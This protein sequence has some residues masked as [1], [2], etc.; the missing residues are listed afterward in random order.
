MASCVPHA[1][2]RAHRA[3]PAGSRAVVKMPRAGEV[4]KEQAQVL[5]DAVRAIITFGCA[6]AKPEGGRVAYDV[7]RARKIRVNRRRR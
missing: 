6:K 7:R 5:A 1:A 2:T 4:F 3:G